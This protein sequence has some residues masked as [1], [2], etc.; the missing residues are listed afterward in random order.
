MDVAPLIEG[1]TE[2]RL[3]LGVGGL[4]VLLRLAA[5]NAALRQD[6]ERGAAYLL[7]AGVV[8]AALATWEPALDGPWRYLG[9]ACDLALCFGL[10][11]AVVGL[12]LWALRDRR[13]R[14]TPKIVRDVIDV[15]LYGVAIV[16]VAQATLHI[17][18][19]SLAATSAALSLVLGLALQETLGNLF[20]GLALQLEHPFQVGDWVGVDA[21]TGRVIQVGWRGTKLE[22]LRHEQVV[23][24]NAAIAK[25]NVINFSRFGRVGHDLNFGVSYRVPPE[26]VRKVIQEALADLPLVMRD[27]KPDVQI[28]AYGAD[29][30]TY[31]VRFFV[32]RYDLIEDGVDA[33]L[34]TL[35]YRFG[36][37]GMEIPFPQRTVHVERFRRGESEGASQRELQDTRSLLR[38]VDFLA[39][40]GDTG[41]AEL[42]ER[43]ERQT[44]GPGET[45]LRAGEAGDT[46]H[47]VADGVVRIVAVVAGKE[48][49]MARLSRREFF[50]EMSL[51]TGEP[52]S[53][54]VF[55]VT[56]VTLLTMR[57]AAFA[58]V[59]ERHQNVAQQ[60]ADVLGKRRAELE[61]LRSASVDEAKLAHAESK[62]I[63]GR[64]LELLK[65]SE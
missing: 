65:G 17:D 4:A 7:F 58:E 43:T 14:P 45:V 16:G 25:A 30:I 2:V 56:P 35:W 52:R 55:A 15:V 13:G 40:L 21:F 63:F 41:L 24:P 53:A 60:L 1:N 10:I 28:E 38:S 26:R 54:N 27:P 11:R 59:L 23:V 32:T 42:A 61:K 31:Q 5:R 50:G 37:E 18:L 34:S 48:K 9:V 20:A 6:L 19:A 49:E 51:I 3:A 36:R 33:I 12:G 8:R 44:F 62:R 47:V 57:R 29:A 64:L 22:T 39:T 46:F